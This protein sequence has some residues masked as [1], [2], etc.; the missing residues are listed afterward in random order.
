[1]FCVYSLFLFFLFFYFH[2][3]RSLLSYWVG[4]YV[5]DVLS[6]SLTVFF[7]VLI[8]QLTELDNYSGS[9]EVIEALILTIYLFVWSVMPFTYLF[10][11]VF[12]QPSTAQRWTSI[13]YIVVGIIIILWQGTTLFPPALL[14]MA[15]NAIGTKNDD[16][17]YSQVCE[18]YWDAMFWH[19]IFWLALLILVEY[20][21]HSY[22]ILNKLGLIPNAGKRTLEI[23]EDV[24]AE[25][26]RIESMLNKDNKENEEHERDTVVIAGLRKV[27]QKGAVCGN[28]SQHVAVRD[29]WFG[30]PQGQ[31]FGFLGVNGAGKTSA[32]AMLTGERHP[33]EGTAYIN[34]Y[35]I[36]NQNMVRRFI[37][38]CPQ[39]DALFDLLTAD[40]HLYFYGKLK[41]LSNAQIKKQ[42]DTLI[43]V[44]NLTKYRNKQAN[45]YSG[46]NKR[47][48]SVAISM[49]GNPPVV[50]LDEPSYVICIS[51]YGCT[52]VCN[53]Y[54]I[55][56]FLI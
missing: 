39:F 3:T 18:K 38:Y 37:G 13:S 54:I 34:N 27:Y 14:G 36:T 46:G 53:C 47:K 8:I 11:F 4:N 31:V 15:L 1:M 23:D 40:E 22:F 19:G 29:L 24:A 49:I 16:L 50:F 55:F 17:K 21:S 56:V 45:T 26:Q 2:V 52:R 5:T 7:I 9:Y 6:S 51:A 32:L 41:G 44:L 25:R 35:P 12:K 30:V 43:K 48:L 42:A 20:L 10:S 33:S 28:G